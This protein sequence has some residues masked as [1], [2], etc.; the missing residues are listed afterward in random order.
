MKKIGRNELCWCGSGKKFKKCH[1]NREQEEKYSFPRLAAELKSKAQ[2]KECLHPKASKNNCSNRIIAAHT[3]QKAGPLK[4]ITDSSNHVC[5]F[6]LNQN[7]GNF[8]K[9]RIGWGIA[10]T[11]QGFC[12]THD[13]ELFTCIEDKEFLSTKEQ[14]FT[15]GY[16]SYAMEYFKKISVNKGLSFLVDKIDR[17]FNPTYQQLIQ[18]DFSTMG[19]GFQHGIAD[20]KTTLDLYTKQFVLNDFSPFSALVFKF[21]GALNI[22]VSGCFSP[23]F[24]IDGTRLQ[25]LNDRTPFIENISINS[26]V[27]NDAHLIVF[28]W[29][30]EFLSCQKFADSLQEVKDVMLS[31][32]LIEL[33]FNYIENTYFNEEWFDGLLKEKQLRLMELAKKVNQYGQPIKF[34]DNNYVN[35]CLDS[36]IRY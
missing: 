32:Y 16:R 1:L 5:V 8:E 11:F 3:I 19:K 20:F 4:H 30:K 36:V 14:C 9:T 31:T 17:G 6:R 33:M 29:P 21:S 26:I 15:V 2:H 34:S 18:K 12:S 22:V 25:H 7:N 28:S 27:T 10:S 35:W 23:E 24:S 13:K